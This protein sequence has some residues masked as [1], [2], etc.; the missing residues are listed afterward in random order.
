MKWGWGHAY[1]F[2][3]PAFVPEAGFG[4]FQLVRLHFVRRFWNQILTWLS[5]SAS[6]SANLALSAVVRY[7]VAANAFSSSSIWFPEN[8]ARPFFSFL[9]SLEEEFCLSSL[10]FDTPSG[11]V[12]RGPG[13]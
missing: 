10:G 4:D 2:Y 13:A 5:E 11:D 9:P 7:C 8:V 6:L 3:F 12:G 1:Y